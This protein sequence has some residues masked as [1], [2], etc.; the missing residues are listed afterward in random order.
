MGLVYVMGSQS[1]VQNQHAWSRDASCLG[2]P[3]QALDVQA[4]RYRNGFPDLATRDSGSLAHAKRLV[5]QVIKRPGVQLL[6]H[7]GK[8]PLHHLLKAA[9]RTW[10]G[11]V[12]FQ[13]LVLAV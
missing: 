2:K 6:V 10:R 12:V 8:G 5:V 13:F 4:V 7:L 1:P 3:R 11:A 9:K